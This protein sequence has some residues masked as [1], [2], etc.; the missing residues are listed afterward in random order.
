MAS[1]ITFDRT[2][3]AQQVYDVFFSRMSAS[4][5]AKR[6]PD[7]SREDVLGLRR[8]FPKFRPENRKSNRTR[9][10]GK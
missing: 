9:R 1:E 3:Y 5:A 6:Y 2:K 10:E 7:L 4:E 8:R